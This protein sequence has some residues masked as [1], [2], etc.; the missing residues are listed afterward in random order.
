MRPGT[1]E[2]LAWWIMSI[3]MSHVNGKGLS[4]RDR[5]HDS[6]SQVLRSSCWA[7]NLQMPG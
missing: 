2:L 3:K 1:W 6:V 4:Q 7:Q 5:E